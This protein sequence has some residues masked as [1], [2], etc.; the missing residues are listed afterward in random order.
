[1]ARVIV[2]TC[3]D[4]R[5]EEALPKVVSHLGVK[6]G[7]YHRITAF[8]CSLGLDHEHDL[9]ELIVK[10]LGAQ[11][12][13]VVDHMDCKAYRRKFGQDLTPEK[14]KE[15]HIERLRLR[16]EEIR[17]DFPEI[18][19]RLFLL[20]DVTPERIGTEVMEVPFSSAVAA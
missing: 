15:L 3:V 6:T 19:V 20:T 13:V 12:V 2:A 18:S 5:M 14:E 16:A 8:G 10:N 1:M 9:Y 7:E 11:E 17:R 4:S